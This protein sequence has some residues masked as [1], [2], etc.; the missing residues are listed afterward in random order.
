[1]KQK[2][3]C[4]WDNLIFIFISGKFYINVA[5]KTHILM[6]FLIYLFKVGGLIIKILFGNGF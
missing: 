6:V 1:M 2:R 3:Y 4:D 5:F